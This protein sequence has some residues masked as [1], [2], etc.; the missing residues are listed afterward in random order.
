[1]TPEPVPDRSA[2]FLRGIN[3]GGKNTVPM[4]ELRAVAQSLGATA[5]S[6]HLNSGNLLASTARPR[7]FA[8]ALARELQ[9]RFGFAV[10][11][12]GRSAAELAE[13]LAADP[14]GATADDE[15]REAVLFFD[16]TAS[17]SERDNLAV[18]LAGKQAPGELVDL[19]PD[20]ARIW[21]AGG[22]HSS[23]LTHALFE[24]QLGMTVTARNLRTV[25]AVSRKLESH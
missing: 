7:E 13:V 16:H 6:T 2:Y 12:V 11:V 18:A 17:A 15:A 24:R 4:A 8:V 19:Q 9:A 14:F 1:M 25:R 10:P 22:I 23:K 21:Y 3:V 20:H 5:V